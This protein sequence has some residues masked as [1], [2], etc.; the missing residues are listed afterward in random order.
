MSNLKFRFIDKIK[1]L[2][3]EEYLKTRKQ[4][5]SILESLLRDEIDDVIITFA[6]NNVEEFTFGHSL[7]QE[8]FTL[9][10]MMKA[11]TSRAD[12]SLLKPAFDAAFQQLEKT[13]YWDRQ[14]V[15]QI[16]L[17]LKE[18][19]YIGS[20]EW[21]RVHDKFDSAYEYTIK[22]SVVALEWTFKLFIQELEELEPEVTHVEVV[23]EVPEVFQSIEVSQEGTGE[24]KEVAEQNKVTA[25]V[26]KE[27]KVIS[28]H[29][30]RKKAKM[31]VESKARAKRVAIPGVW[32]VGRRRQ[33][34]LFRRKKRALFF[35]SPAFRTSSKWMVP[36]LTNHD[37]I[38][39]K[40]VSNHKR[41]KWMVPGLTNHDPSKQKDVY[42]NAKKNVPVL[43]KHGVYSK[44]DVFKVARWTDK[45]DII[46][47]YTVQEVFK[48]ASGHGGECKDEVQLWL[49]DTG[50]STEG[51]A[52]A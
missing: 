2:Y 16:V 45:L 38:K 5:L 41:I 43:T 32:L 42:T 31:K 35:A 48:E 29:L 21:Q 28:S 11:D 15:L 6:D 23:D 10:D 39:K 49:C 27:R 12:L 18:G 14:M 46:K 47:F 37:P 52:A 3:Q 34:F 19:N 8:L 33:L 9:T 13:C 7:F 22:R 30:K 50:G 20:N 51:A 25:V 24:M 1:A 26:T 40:D 17:F 36:S 44:K 4:Y